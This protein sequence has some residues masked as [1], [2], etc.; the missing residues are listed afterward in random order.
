MQGRISSF[1]RMSVVAVRQ[2]GHVRLIDTPP[3]ANNAVPVVK[4]EASERRKPA[5]AAFALLP[6]QPTQTIP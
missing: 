3:S 4:L 6:Q 5:R 2:K 1:Q